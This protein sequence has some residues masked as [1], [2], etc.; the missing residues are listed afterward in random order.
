MVYPQNW[1][2]TCQL[3]VERRTEK[4]RRPKTDVN[5]CA[6]Q[7]KSIITNAHNRTSCDVGQHRTTEHK[8]PTL[9]TK[10]NTSIRADV[11]WSYTSGGTRNST[12]FVHDYLSVKSNVLREDGI[13][14]HTKT[15]KQPRA[16]P[17][18]ISSDTHL[19]THLVR[20]R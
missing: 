20:P 10:Y 13:W 19:A 6:T 17:R 16:E 5:H 2:P 9:A 1:S 11:E 14:K 3:Q 18:D 8:E 15:D 4:A 7:P 12:G